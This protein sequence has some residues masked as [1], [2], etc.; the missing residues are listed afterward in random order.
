MSDRQRVPTAMILLAV[1]LSVVQWA[2]CIGAFS[3]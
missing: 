2:P 3:S 1:I